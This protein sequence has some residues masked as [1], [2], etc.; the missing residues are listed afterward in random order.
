M[1]CA[2]LA[3]V[4][5]P[6]VDRTLDPQIGN[7]DIPRLASECPTRVG[8][9]A[10]FRFIASAMR[11]RE[12]LFALSDRAEQ[13]GEVDEVLGN[14]VDDLPLSLHLA[15]NRTPLAD[16]GRWRTSTSPATDTRRPSRVAL[17]SPAGT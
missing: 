8:A 17:R 10:V 12:D 3:E 14:Y 13:A 1:Q 6:H 4:S 11:Q 7:V 9:A 5:R 2:G 15:A 16:P